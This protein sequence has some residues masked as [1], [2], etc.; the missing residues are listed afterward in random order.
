MVCHQVG[1]ILVVDLQKGK[2]VSEH[3]RPEKEISFLDGLRRPFE[4]PL[5]QKTAELY[6]RVTLGVRLCGHKLEP[7]RTRSSQK[8][9]SNH[10]GS[11][12]AEDA[13][14]LAVDSEP[15]WPLAR[16]FNEAH[17]RNGVG[18]VG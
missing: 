6:E 4:L 14:Q 3:F 15:A 2:V 16:P 13:G 7:I 10:S 1:N 9:L 5:R 18:Y 11:A 8:A 17:G 12:E